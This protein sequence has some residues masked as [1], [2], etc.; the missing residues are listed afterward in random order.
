M[1]KKI[2]LLLASLDFWNIIDESEEPPSDDANIKVK[3]EYKC[4]E[5]KAFGMI[6]SN[7]DD[8]N[9]SHVIAC[10]GQVEA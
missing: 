7:F 6:A 2:E 5:K 1:E 9:F 3:K 10:N 8:A 4:C